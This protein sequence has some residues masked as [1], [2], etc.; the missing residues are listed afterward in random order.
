VDE[1]SVEVFFKNGEMTMTAL[2]L[3]RS[4]SKEVWFFS[5]SQKEIP[6]QVRG[7]Y[8]ASKQV[9]PFPEKKHE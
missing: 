3:P 9:V 5:D 4:D 6:M 1:T 2:I 8:L 7:A